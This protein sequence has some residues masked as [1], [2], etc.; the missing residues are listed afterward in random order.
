MPCYPFLSITE[1][2]QNIAQRACIGFVDF[3]VPAT[4]ATNSDELLA[5]DIEEFRQT[6]A[7]CSKFICFKLHVLTRWTLPIVVFQLILLIRIT[8][9]YIML[10]GEIGKHGKFCRITL[11][12]INH[13]G[14]DS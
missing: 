13:R 2:I 10:P 14:I 11:R 9:H 5:L 4:C 8:A 7:G 6:P 1:E 12:G 3:G